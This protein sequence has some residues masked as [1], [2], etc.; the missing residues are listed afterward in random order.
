V[1]FENGII[2]PFL[3]HFMQTKTLGSQDVKAEDKSAF[4]ELVRQELG[5]LE[6]CNYARYRWPIGKTEQW[7]EKGRPH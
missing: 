4:V 6:S 5:I 7:I 1:R 2:N 3:S